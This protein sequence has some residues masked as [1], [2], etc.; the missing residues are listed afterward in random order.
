MQKAIPV[1]KCKETIDTYCANLEIVV[2]HQDETTGD[3]ILHFNI[4]RVENLQQWLSTFIL[5]IWK[6]MDYVCILSTKVTMK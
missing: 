3:M 4:I 5:Q 6:S 1:K 2:L